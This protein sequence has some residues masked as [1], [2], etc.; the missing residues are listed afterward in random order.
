MQQPGQLSQ[1]IDAMSLYRST[2]GIPKC[3]SLPFFVVRSAL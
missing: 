2:T 1:I 3:H